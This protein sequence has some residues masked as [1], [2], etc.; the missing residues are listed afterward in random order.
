[1]TST[2]SASRRSRQLVW[3]FAG[4][5][6]A[7]TWFAILYKIQTERTREIDNIN[8]ANL[9]LASSLEEHTLRTLKEVDQAVLF[10]KFRYEKEKGRVPIRE[11][12]Q[13]G[14]RTRSKGSEAARAT[15]WAPSSARRRR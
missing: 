15:A 7:L 10:L 12:V 6:L 5:L 14:M 9:N 8:R 3:L 2:S 4:A 13:E 1:M 11:Y